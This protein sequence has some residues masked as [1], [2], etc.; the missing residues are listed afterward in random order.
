[1]A[2]RPRRQGRESWELVLTAASTAL[3]TA[4]RRAEPS[5]VEPD[6]P[7]APAA[8]SGP[9]GCCVGLCC[10]VLSCDVPGC[11]LLCGTECGCGVSDVWRCDL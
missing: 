2:F 7:V 3:H 1:M 6:L 9:V 4:P 10:A 8:V 11:A 5:R